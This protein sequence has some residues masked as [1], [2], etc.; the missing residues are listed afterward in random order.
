MTNRLV[1]SRRHL[2][3]AG[4]ALAAVQQ[5]GCAAESGR[6]PV[7]QSG[8]AG[9]GPGT[10]APRAYDAFACDEEPAAYVLWVGQ[11]PRLTALQR[12]LERVG[13]VVYELPF[14]RSPAELRGVIV[15]PSYA[16]A[17]A[18]YSDYMKRHGAELYGFVDGANLLLQLPQDADM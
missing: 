9:A 6:P 5:L 7:A 3:R 16:S 15:L 12:R 17:D 11:G 18:A 2:L 1:L 13:F 14:D 4:A 8:G 10:P